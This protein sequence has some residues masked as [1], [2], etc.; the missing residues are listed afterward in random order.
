MTAG[1]SGPLAPD[2]LEHGKA[3]FVELI[4]SPSITHDSAGS[5]AGLRR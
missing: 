2:Q 4:A 1:A 5:F 3:A